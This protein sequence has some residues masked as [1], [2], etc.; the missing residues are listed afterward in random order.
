MVVSEV[1]KS[2]HREVRGWL[3]ES[4]RR[5]EVDAVCAHSFAAKRKEKYGEQ[6]PR[7]PSM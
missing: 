5:G 2:G 6:H 7:S 3:G 1:S 4:W